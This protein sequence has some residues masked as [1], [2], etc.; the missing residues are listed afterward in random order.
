V[1]CLLYF[2]IVSELT[3][4][5]DFISETSNLN[6]SERICVIYMTIP[7]QYIRLGF[8]VLDFM[9]TCLKENNK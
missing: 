8:S 2:K 9:N 3:A 4:F 7:Y 1:T 5:N 6:L